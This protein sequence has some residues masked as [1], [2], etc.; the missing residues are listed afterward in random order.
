V[1]KLEEEALRAI[2]RECGA[3]EEYYGER[4]WKQAST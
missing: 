2:C 3:P 1:A 4:R